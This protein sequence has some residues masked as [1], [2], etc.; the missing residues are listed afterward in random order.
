MGRVN[1][2]SESSLF[3]GLTKVNFMPVDVYR[4]EDSYRV[5]MDIPGVSAR[6]IDVQVKR[7]TL[8]VSVVS[9]PVRSSGDLLLS[10]R[11]SGTSTR[12]ISLGEELD[13]EK[14]TARYENGTLTLNLELAQSARAKKIEVTGV[15]SETPSIAAGV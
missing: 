2:W 5:F 10:E 15:N 3:A 7:N 1:G 13:P 11:A 6:D 9:N 14:V 8:V 12:Q 4:E